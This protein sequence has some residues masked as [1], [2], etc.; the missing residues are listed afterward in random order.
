MRVNL[1]GFGTFL[2]QLKN[3]GM[4]PH[5]VGDFPA[6][7]DDVAA[8]ANSSDTGGTA[9]GAILDKKARIL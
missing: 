2:Q 1:H 9:L 5:L 7:L 4:N 8:E 6:M 3:A